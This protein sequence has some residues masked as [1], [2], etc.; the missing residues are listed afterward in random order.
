MQ[1]IGDFISLLIGGAFMMS[2]LVYVILQ[3]YALAV[4]R[5]NWRRLAGIPLIFMVP[6]LLFTVK[7]YRDQSNLWPVPLIFSSAFA[8][9][10]LAIEMIV[11][12]ASR[13]GKPPPMVD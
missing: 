8:V 6:I 5:G 11:R 12:R 10:V 13:N 7:A 9:L 4:F 1:K 3:I 2:P